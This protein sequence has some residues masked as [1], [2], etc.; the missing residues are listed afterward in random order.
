MFQKV[1]IGTI[2]E[3]GRSGRDNCASIALLIPYKNEADKKS[4]YKIARSL[5]IKSLIK[6]ELG[7]GRWETMFN[8]S[9]QDQI[10][11]MRF[12][13][14]PSIP[15]QYDPDMRS[16]KNIAWNLRVLNLMARTGLIRLS[17]FR[18]DQETQRDL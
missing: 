15:P 6:D 17:G 9:I 10:T 11:K 5:S 14:D 8:N 4:D 3:I 16:K 18:F 2:Q 1:L 13:V 7:I 12:W